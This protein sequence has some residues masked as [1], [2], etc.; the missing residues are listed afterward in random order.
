MAKWT[1]I[2]GSH[3]GERDSIVIEVPDKFKTAAEV[4]EALVGGKI[5]DAVFEA[6]AVIGVTRHSQPAMGGFRVE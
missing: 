5:Q 3:K 2:Y 6:E 4:R 1:V